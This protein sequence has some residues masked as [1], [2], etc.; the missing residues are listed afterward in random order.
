MA[1][2]PHRT[3]THR[4][5]R[6]TRTSRS[7]AAAVLL[8]TT[9]FLAAL[10]GTASGTESAVPRVF[11]I[12]AIGD[13]Y[14]AG[15]GAPQTDGDYAYDTTARRWVGAPAAVWDSSDPTA[16]R[17]HRSP[18]S[19]F[20]QAVQLLRNGFASAGIRI[21]IRFRS[22]ACSGGSIRFGVD[23]ASGLRVD[24]PTGGGAL[25]AYCGVAPTGCPG[26]QAPL[27]PQVRQVRDTF[28]TTPVDALLVSFGG[29][30]FGFAHTIFLCAI[31]QYLGATGPGYRCNDDP[32][33]ELML[34]AAT[35]PTT[36]TT[37]E[38]RLPELQRGNALGTDA[39]VRGCAFLSGAAVVSRTCTPTFRA[40]FDLLGRAL[41]G[42]V[43]STFIRCSG[44][45]E[46][47]AEAAW[48]LAHPLS[49]AA[50]VGTVAGSGC[51]KR[52]GNSLGEALGIWVRTER[53]YPALQRAPERVYV[54]TYP[55]A[56][57]D[58]NGTLCNNRPADDRLIRNVVTSES[59]FVRTEVRPLL[60][61]EIQAAGERQDWTVIGL[62]V[63]FRHGV[64]ANAGARWFNTN[65]DSLEHQG[66]IT[67][68]SATLS[69]A[70]RVGRDALG[71]SDGEPALG[72][73]MVHPNEAGYD[74]LYAWRVGNRLRTQICTK[75]AIDPCPPLRR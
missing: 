20:G 4:G 63:A 36:T 10:T 35:R 48:A 8:A 43:P 56:V 64:C 73:G 39:L 29:N 21:S 31:T 58:E 16:A 18:R 52:L 37:V 71:I 72:G 67:G 59:S 45:Q 32:T 51:V 12:V 11:Q 42:L 62:P 23:S 50:P 54:T 24:G 38:A 74:Q 46:A 5:T 75:F 3:R 9:G 6:R 34:R 69:S 17:C 40:S 70:L 41:R 15:E 7:T 27:A 53:T 47:G 28:G 30:D 13:S 1:G 19:G 65:R 61:S 60:N 33:L 55:G 44:V 25:T 57:E 2:S 68:M 26:S 49:G 14:G 22:F 66:E